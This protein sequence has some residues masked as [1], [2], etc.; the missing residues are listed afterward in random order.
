VLHE[1]VVE[2]GALVGANAGRDQSHARAGGCDGA[3]RPG[4]IREGAASLEQ[5][6]HGTR[7]TTSNEASATGANY[8]AWIEDRMDIVSVGVWDRCARPSAVRAGRRDGD[9][10]RVARLR[11]GVGARGGRQG[12]VG[13]V[14]VAPC[15]NDDT[16]GRDGYRQHLLARCDLDG[17]G[18]QDVDRSVPTIVS[19]WASESVIA[20]WSRECRGLTYEKPIATM[21]SYLE[22]MDQATYLG[23]APSTAPVRVLGALRDRMMNLAAELADGAHPYNVP[24]E[25]T[26]HAR[27][28]LGAD[29]LLAPEVAVTLERDATKARELGRVHLAIYMNLPNYTKQP[30]RSWLQRRRLCRWW[31]AIGS[32]MRWSGGAAS[33]ALPRW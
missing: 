3:R 32:S 12:P 16:R 14:R 21:R 29:K 17:A 15:R 20:R 8:T 24:P 30:A 25:H 31:Q 4:Q 28:V 26:A 19:C 5:N 23:P 27:E 22:R 18:A 10:D 13:G 9:R 11:C 33:S 1:A 6:L 2:T 7:R